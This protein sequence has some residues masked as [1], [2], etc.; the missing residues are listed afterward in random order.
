METKSLSGVAAVAAI[1][2]F[3]MTSGTRKPEEAG[4][5]RSA[6]TFLRTAYVAYAALALTLAS[7]HFAAAQECGDVNASGAVTATDSLLVLSK[8]VGIDVALQCLAGGLISTGQTQ[9]FGPGSDGDIQSGIPASYTDNGDGTITDNNT[10]LMWQ[11]QDDSPGGIHSRGRVW[12]WSSGDPWLLDGSVDFFLSALNVQKFA[13]YDDW[14]LPNMK[15][16]LTLLSFEGNTGFA[17]PAFH[18]HPSCID[19]LDVTLAGCSCTQFQPG[20]VG[21]WSSTTVITSAAAFLRY[22]GGSIVTEWNSKLNLK[23]ARAVRGGL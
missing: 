22:A 3:T 21:Y 14:R 15:E 16:L 4:R 10:G 5:R 7:P 17:P 1:V 2:S 23:H 6:P 11:K 18:R 19:C 12:S 20:N 8:S 13:G 9:S